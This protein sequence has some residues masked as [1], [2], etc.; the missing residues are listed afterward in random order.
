MCS[1]L[2]QYPDKIV[3]QE[4]GTAYWKL[5]QYTDKP[6]QFTE[7]ICAVQFTYKVEPTGTEHW[8]S[9]TVYVLTSTAQWLSST[10][11][12]KL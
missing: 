7:K 9:V 6:V 10:V 1:E 8:E 2:V 12:K 5:E 4:T 3:H 11:T